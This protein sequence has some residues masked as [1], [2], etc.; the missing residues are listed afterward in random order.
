V[1]AGARFLEAFGNALPTAVLSGEESLVMDESSLE[2][3]IE[4]L[5][6]IAEPDFECAMIA[7]EGM[8]AVSYTGPAGVRKAWTDWLGGFERVR[9]QFEDLL[10]SERG[11]VFL[12]KQ[13]GTTRYGVELE[14]PSAMV[15]KLGEG[16]KLERLEFHLDRDMALRSA[17]IDPERGQSSQA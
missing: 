9:F 5:E 6:R 2:I 1:A 16:G 10:E 11:L 12:A 3:L 14:Q 13:I 8:A 17:G 4:G 15:A 7:S